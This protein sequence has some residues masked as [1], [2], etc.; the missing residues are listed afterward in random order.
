M[1]GRPPD[2]EPGTEARQRP[3]FVDVA[4]QTIRNNH[5]RMTTIQWSEWSARILDHGVVWKGW[6]E[7]VREDHT[8]RIDMDPPD[9]LASLQDVILDGVDPS[10]AATLEKNEMVV[11]SGVISSVQGVLGTTQVFLG[12]ARIH[13]GSEAPPDALFQHRL[14]PRAQSAEIETL[15]EDERR[16]VADR[17]REMERDIM[18]ARQKEGCLSDLEAEDKLLSEKERMLAPGNSRATQKEALSGLFAIYC[19]LMSS[20]EKH[21]REAGVEVPDRRSQMVRQAIRVYESALRLSFSQKDWKECDGIRQG[22]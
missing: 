1:D 4:Y 11:F 14:H 19:G 10:I 12:Y 5:S 17:F 8:V 18:A 22:P 13:D 7:D 3:V 9:E 15:G 2:K 21:C 6:V 16:A 20:T